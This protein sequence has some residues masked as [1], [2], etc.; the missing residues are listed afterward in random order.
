ML[1]IASAL[2]HDANKSAPSLRGSRRLAFLRTASELLMDANF[3]GH[4]THP[5]SIPY[6]LKRNRFLKSG[7]EKT[8]V[9]H[10]L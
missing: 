7:K 6:L 8:L 3:T 5:M 2:K 10:I 4:K 1:F 9:D